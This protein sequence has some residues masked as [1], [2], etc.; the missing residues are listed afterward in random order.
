MIYE[1]TSNSNSVK[2]KIRDGCNTSG[3]PDRFHFGDRTVSGPLHPGRR[4]T[5]QCR[6]LHGSAAQEGNSDEEE[7]EDKK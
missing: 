6:R 3:H 7:E 2:L 4:V 5:E 1:K